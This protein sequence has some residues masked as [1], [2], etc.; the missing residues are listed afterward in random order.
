MILDRNANKGP[1]YGGAQ[2]EQGSKKIQALVI[3]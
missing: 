1:R 3:N 2:N